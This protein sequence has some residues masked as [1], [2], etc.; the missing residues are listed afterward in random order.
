MNLDQQVC[1]L[2]YAKRLKELKVKQESIFCWLQGVNT[3]EY[4]IYPSTPFFPDINWR[5]KNKI[6][7]HGYSA[8]TVA[9]LGE[10][11]PYKIKNKY[12]LCHKDNEGFS[13][14]YKDC[15]NHIHYF[16][17]FDKSEADVRAKM[18]IFLLENRLIKN[19]NIQKD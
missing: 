4:F 5:D 1:A 19:D 14:S 10:L 6:P 13:I 16:G 11:L 2:K 15:N 12:I 7:D 18:L 8:F 9:E 17:Q 3:E